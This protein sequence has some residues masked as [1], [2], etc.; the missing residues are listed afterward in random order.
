MK[1]LAISF[2]LP[3]ASFFLVGVLL[4]L[5][6]FHLDTADQKVYWMIFTWF[7]VLSFLACVGIIIQI[8]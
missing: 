4:K 1:S 3:F 2:I 6:G 7:M 8:L 5:F